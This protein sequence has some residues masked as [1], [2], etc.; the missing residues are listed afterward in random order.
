MHL[1]EK[2]THMLPLLI[3]QQIEELRP[4]DNFFGR[5]APEKCDF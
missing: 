4:L 2:L 1:G 3:L 5:R